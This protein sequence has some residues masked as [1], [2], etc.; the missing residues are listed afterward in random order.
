MATLVPRFNTWRMVQEY[1]ERY[2]IAPP[3][4]AAGR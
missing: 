1:T 2:Y 3:G 4:E